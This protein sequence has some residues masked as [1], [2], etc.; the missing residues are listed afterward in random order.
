MRETAQHVWVALHPAHQDVEL[1]QVAAT[2]ALHGL[3]HRRFARPGAEREEHGHAER[4]HRLPERTQVLPV[5]RLGAVVVGV[6]R[7]EL[8]GVQ[9]MFFNG[10]NG[11]G[12]D[13]IEFAGQAPLIDRSH[14]IDALWIDGDRLRLEDGIA[15]QHGIDVQ[16]NFIDASIVHLG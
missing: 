10:V 4:G 9:A 16:Q 11:L 8:D 13:G 14:R 12:D 15:A 5:P 2:L 3:Q 7:V 6:G 1:G